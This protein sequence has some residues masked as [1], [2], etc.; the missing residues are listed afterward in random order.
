MCLIFF[1]RPFIFKLCL[2]EDTLKAVGPFYMV[3]IQGE[4]KVPTQ[5]NGKNPVVD[6][7][8]VISIV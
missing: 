1:L 5:G 7:E 3:Y 8:L 4:V 6:S 2:S